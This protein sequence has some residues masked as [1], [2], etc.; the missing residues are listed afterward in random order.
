[1]GGHGRSWEVAGGHG[2]SR[3]VTGGHHLRE[4]L[5]EA[6]AAAS[7]GAGARGEL[8]HKVE[9]VDGALGRRLEPSPPLALLLVGGEHRLRERVAQPDGRDEATE[10]PAVAR[11]AVVRDAAAVGA[12]ESGERVVVRRHAALRRRRL[13]LCEA[14][15]AL[16]LLGGHRLHDVVLGLERLPCLL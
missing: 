10:R 13:E 5:D 14:R 12:L 8:P 2:R 4:E 9:L 6:L 15:G 7:R 11:L 3:E 1:M 16:T